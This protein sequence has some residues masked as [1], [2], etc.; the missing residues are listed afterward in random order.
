MMFDGS[1]NLALKI[2]LF[3]NTE[4]YLYNFRRSLAS[5]LVE[6]GHDV[7]LLSPSGPYGQK[8]LEMGFNWRS[9][10]L[11]RRSLNPFRELSVLWSL[12]KIMREENPDIIHGFTIK[13]A[14]Y[15]AIV[16]RIIKARSVSSVAGLGYVF[17]NTDM[18]AKLLMPIIRSIMK[19]TLGG[20]TSHIILQ[21]PDD[22]RYF[23]IAEIVDPSNMSLIPGSGV[24]LE[25]FAAP[26]P[27]NRQKSDPHKI[28]LAAR[29]LWDKGIAEF[30]EAA[31]LIK[32]E[33]RNCE[34]LLAGTPDEGNPA[35]IPRACLLEW[36]EKGLIV[37]LG[38]VDNMPTLFADANIVVL[39]SYREGLPKSL[40]E[41]AAC[42][43][44][45]VAT[46]VPGCREVISHEIDG[47]LVPAKDAQALAEAIMRLLDD[48][49]LARRLGLA[50]LK[51]ATLQFDERIIN[52]QTMTIYDNL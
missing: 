40:I 47:L 19:L 7:I 42:A 3:A 33:G 44:P 24:N 25:R 9:I 18:R 31:R 37:C 35:S 13:C 27:E 8:L 20:K 26:K 41:A 48:P 23:E 50:A 11:K 49:V 5:A 21:N 1:G 29:L 6:A 30:V 14:V 46:D 43:R 38:H 32:A 52:A 10:A 45:L 34:F 17:T 28:V 22:F 16:A 15:G 51:K 12:L 36:E 4:W 39:P 2:V